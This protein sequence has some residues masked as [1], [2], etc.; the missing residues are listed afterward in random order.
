MK[1]RILTFLLL[2]VCIVLPFCTV[3]NFILRIIITI[4]IYSLLSMGNMVITGY[5]GLIHIGHAALYGVG[6]YASA[7]LSTRFGLPFFA[8][9]LLVGLFTGLVGYILALPCLRVRADFLSLITLAFAQCFISIANNWTS[10]TNGPAGIAGIPPIKLFGVSLITQKSYY[11]LA[12]FVLVLT[13]LAVKGLLNSCTGRAMMAIRDDEI[14]A[15]AMGIN[16]NTYKIM[17][18][19]IGSVL[20]GFAGCLMAHYIRFIGPTNFSIDES[21][22]ILQMC[23]IGGLGSLAGAICGSAFFTILPELLRTFAVY[24]TGIGG[25]IMLL[26]MLIRPQGIL[27]S[28]AFAGNYNLLKSLQLSFKH[29]IEKCAP[30]KKE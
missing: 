5:C 6:A 29:F 23:I 27:G 1:K 10:L 30:H 22:L 3:S 9:F 4:F 17:S 16:V 24:R 28:A 8:E 14:S 19:V 15:S 2:A 26:V 18:F 12:F 21:L 20:A 7:I 11:Y 25:I 13:Y